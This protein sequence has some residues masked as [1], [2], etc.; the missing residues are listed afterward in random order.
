MPSDLICGFLL[1]V[2]ELDSSSAIFSLV[3]CVSH[4]SS[5]AADALT[6]KM[7]FQYKQMHGSTYILF[8]ICPLTSTGFAVFSLKYNTGKRVNGLYAVSLL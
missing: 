3:S 2:T 4:M 1:A 6:L 7:H 8:S 5:I